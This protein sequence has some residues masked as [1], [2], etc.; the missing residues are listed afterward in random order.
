V[1]TSGWDRTVRIWDGNSGKQ[2]RWFGPVGES[3]NDLALSRDG[4]RILLGTYGHAASVWNVETGAVERAFQG[5]TDNVFAVAFSP[6]ERTVA[7]GSWDG[8]VRLWNPDTGQEVRRLLQ[9]STTFA[10]E[11]TSVQAI[12]FSPDGRSIAVGCMDN[13]VRLWSV[14]T[15]EE[16][17]RFSGHTNAIESTEFS[18]DG[19]LLLAGSFDG[20]ARLWDVRTGRE[21]RL[22]DG[23]ASPVNGI[24]IAGNVMA[25]A[26][27]D[28]QSRIWDLP[29]GQQTTRLVGHKSSV[30][31]IDLT[32]DGQIAVTGSEDGSAAIWDVV[33]GRCLRRLEGHSG[34]V[35][36]LDISADG[37]RVAT[38]GQ[39]GTSRTWSIQ[40]GAQDGR[41]D[42]DASWIKAIA[43]TPDGEGLVTGTWK[44]RITRWDL[45]RGSPVWQAQNEASIV[46]SLAASPDGRYVLTGD[47]S[48]PDVARLWDA[49]YGREIRSIDPDGWIVQ[50]VA[51][52]SDSRLAITGDA[53][54][55]AKLWDV[56]TGKLLRTLGG[57]TGFVNGVAFLPDGRWVA[58]GSEDGTVRIWDPDTGD[59]VCLV[60]SF[61][62]GNW[63]VTDR[64]GRFDAGDVGNAEGL[65]WVVG[66]ESVSLDQLKERYYEPDCS[67][68]LNKKPLRDVASFAAR[69]VELHPEVTI[70]HAPD[71]S[72]PVL[73]LRASNRGGGIGPVAVFVNNTEVTADARPTGADPQAEQLEIA[74][75]LSGSRLFYDDRDSEISLVPYNAEGYLAGSR[76]VRAAGRLHTKAAPAGPPDLW[77]AVAGVSEYQGKDLGLRLASKDAEVFADA[78]QIGAK[79]LFGA[80]RVHI[81]RLSDKRAP[82]T[83]T[84]LLAAFK[85]LRQAK[86]KD[87]LVVYLAGHGLTWG[88]PEGDY[89][90]LLKEAMTGDLKDPA[91]REQTAISSRE[92]TELI[93]QVPAA[94]KVLVLDTCHSGR[95][96]AELAAEREISSSQRAFE[97]MKDRTGM[98]ILAGSA[99]DAV[100]Y[101]ASPYGQGLLTYSLLMGMRGL[102]CG[103]RN[104]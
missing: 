39:D 73:R 41:Y 77:A 100:S 96:I 89:Y 17:R 95:L 59:L 103:T 29:T 24:A 10:G 28:G 13:T 27:D 40:T 90:F 1:V 60:V 31:A 78:L 26:G 3:V 16:I 98:F 49:E 2:V 56:G 45:V 30:Y 55:S 57:H 44:G 58:T 52:S 99:A 12:A 64:E 6:D 4:R 84:R 48:A 20:T 11:L 47:G 87:I 8:T 81:L 68:L 36:A 34:A 85:E 72:D 50:S 70:T 32:T 18:R 69:G 63:A 35:F 33:A 71:A 102:L 42:R 38:G 80:G 46:Q 94:K 88:G 74:V 19:P 9:T 15:G 22:L 14:D 62:D 104:S 101:E 43:F 51:F 83:R 23:A 66:L 54:H 7:S 65:H 91:V 79:R 97:R 25:T 92:L 86:P 61:R 82:A 67:K 37:R 93:K 5:H 21:I 75:D 53:H 76:N